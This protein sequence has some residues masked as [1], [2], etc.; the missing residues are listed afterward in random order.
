MHQRN[1][2]GYEPYGV[3]AYKIYLSNLGKINFSH[4]I[5]FD[6][7]I[8]FSSTSCVIK[9]IKSMHPTKAITNIKPPHVVTTK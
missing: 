7:R 3:K 1:F 9:E 6:E 2:V 5:E 4:F 8:L